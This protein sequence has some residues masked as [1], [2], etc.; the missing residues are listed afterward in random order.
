MANVTYLLGAG[1]SKNSLPI[2]NQFTSRLIKFKNKIEQLPFNEIGT[3][4]S[5]IKNQLLGDISIILPELKPHQTIDTYAKRLFLT[6]DRKLV[7]LKRILITFFLFEQTLEQYPQENL[8]KEDKTEAIDKRY[9]GFIASLISPKVGNLSMPNNVNILTWNYDLQLEL[10][11]A[12]YQVN[13]KR[14][15]ENYNIYPFK[16]DIITD[17]FSIVHLNGQAL[18]SSKDQ[19]G[20]SF[21]EEFI[22]F[23][24]SNLSVCLGNALKIYQRLIDSDSSDTIER[25]SY[26]WESNRESKPLIFKTA[27]D[28]F[29]H[30]AEKTECLVLIGYSFPFV[31]RVYDKKLFENILKSKKLKSI[32]IQDPHSKNI[33]SIISSTFLTNYPVKY[34]HDESVTHFWLPPEI[35]EIFDTES[36]YDFIFTP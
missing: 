5:E 32:Y 35:D 23:S 33:E 17:K 30:I 18:L 34:F 3:E 16:R 6:N 20:K 12:K 27:H 9:D 7:Q 28:Q 14:V 15:Y 2:L 10:S 29:E 31:N 11:L 4:L 13:L 8:I 25:F 36:S 21:I 26:A 24:S 1:A 22:N 19:Y